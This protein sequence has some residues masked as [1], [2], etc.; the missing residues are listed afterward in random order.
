MSLNK[1]KAFKNLQ[2]TDQYNFK[3]KFK[4]KVNI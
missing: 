3:I 4:N 1:N 2:T